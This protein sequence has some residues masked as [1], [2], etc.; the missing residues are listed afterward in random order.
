MSQ[1]PTPGDNSRTLVGS[2]LDALQAPSDIHQINFAWL[3]RLRWAAFFGQSAVIIASG[4]GLGLA[5]PYTVLVAILLLEVLSNLALIGWAKTASAHREAMGALVLMADIVFLTV[6]LFFTGG[7]ANPFSLLYL[8]HVALAALVLR[9]L[10]TWAVTVISIAAY[11]GLHFVPTTAESLPW[12]Q[13]PDIWQLETQGRWV[14]FVVSASVIA[15]FINMIQR[16]LTQRDEELLRARREHMKNEKLASLATLAAGAAHEFSTPLST[17]AIVS[18]ELKRGLESQDAPQRFTDDAA[19]IRQQVE[20]CRD[21]LQQMSADAGESMGEI[22]RPV[23]IETLIDHTL[24]G[25]RDP[26]RVDVHIESDRDAKLTVPPTA[27]GQALRGLVNNALEASDRDQHIEFMARTSDD[28]LIVEISDDGTGMAPEVLQ[29]VDE[30][31]FT[32]KTTGDSMGLGVFLARTLIEKIDGTMSIDSVPGEGTDVVI[33][34]PDP[35][36]SDSPLSPDPQH[37]AFSPAQLQHEVSS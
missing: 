5:L 4:V 13:A 21:I 10:W 6:L 27:L 7:P 30:P 14:A 35:P 36:D 34:L 20:R 29:R 22:A 19:L 16:A 8:I 31:F 24:D 18:N 9:P 23:A 33:R 25:C 26:E 28:E 32:T 15:F 3:I 2:S 11:I 1:P 12:A 37:P 17:I